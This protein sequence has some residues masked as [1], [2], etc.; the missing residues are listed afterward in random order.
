MD[1]AYCVETS[2]LIKLRYPW[3]PYFWQTLY[4]GVLGGVYIGITL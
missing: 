3:Y 1:T 2:T 4:M